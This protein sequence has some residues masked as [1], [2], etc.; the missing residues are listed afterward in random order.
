MRARAECTNSLEVN[1][2]RLLQQWVLQHVV[3]E[4][5]SVVVLDVG[6]NVGDWSKS[7]LDVAGGL[8]C[9]PRIDLRAFEPSPEAAAICRAAL[10]ASGTQARV[11]VED[12]AASDRR[13]TAQLH[14]SQATAGTNSLVGASLIEDDSSAP[15]LRTL[16]VTTNTID[17]YI[18][19]NSIDAVALLKIDTEGHDMRVLYGA[20]ESLRAGRIGV[21]QFE[22]NHRWIPARCFLRDAF[23]LARELNLGI[24]KLTNRGIEGYRAWHP[25]LE[26]FFE[27][28]YVLWSQPLE[29]ALPLAWVTFDGSNA[30]RDA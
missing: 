14:M 22:Y 2:E 15:C 25:E 12:L 3:R 1:G 28:N 10:E 20:K 16:N 24:G 7:L 18:A 26:R 13:G 4:A 23:E 11:R 6:A 17:N 29:A 8:G 21:A 27:G 5:G 9:G 30:M 19:I